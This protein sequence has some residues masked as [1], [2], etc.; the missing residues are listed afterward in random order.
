MTVATV[1]GQIATATN[2]VTGLNG[3]LAL[4]A[5]P[6]TTTNL[7]VA[8]VLPVITGQTISAHTFSSR[9]DDGG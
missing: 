8:C 5:H 6:W 4:T 9:H 7:A 2:A 1:E 3:K